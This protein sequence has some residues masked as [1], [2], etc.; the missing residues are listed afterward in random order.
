MATD[1][2]F[3]LA[4]LAVVGRHLPVALRTFLLTL[5]VVDD[6]IAIVIIAIAYTSDLSLP[7]LAAAVVPLAV[8]GVLVQ[9]RLILIWALV[10]LALLTWGLVHASGVHATVAG[11]LLAFTLPAHTREGEDHSVCENLEHRV[12]PIS[13]GLAV[14]LFALTAAGVRVVDGGLGQAVS[15]PVF[16]A[17][18]VGL[19]IGKPVGV[20]FGTWATARFTRAELDASIG[21]PEV[22]GVALLSGVGFTVSLLI[23]ELSFGAMSPRQDHVK[24]AVLVGSLL[25]GLL[26]AVA[27]RVRSGHHRDQVAS[28]G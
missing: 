22:T 23:G 21:W 25:A 19:V 6:L 20:L 2:A 3:A 27:L 15:D 28:S 9:R 26:A 11:V 5:A 4:I 18:I 13:A 7:A 12:E 10:P 16:L 8:F 24:L 14:P 17:V 1:I